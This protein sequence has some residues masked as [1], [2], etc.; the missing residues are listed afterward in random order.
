LMLS[1]FV[2][3][4]RNLPL[5]VQIVSNVLPATHY[6]TLTKRLIIQ[7]CKSS[8]FPGTVSIPAGL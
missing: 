2:F 1:G 3:D 7:S 4:T 6:M 8:V 5:I